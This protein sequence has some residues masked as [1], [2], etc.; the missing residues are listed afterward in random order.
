M[1]IYM[2]KRGNGERKKIL[3]SHGL[4]IWV[5]TGKGG[6]NGDDIL[7]MLLTDS[8][9]TPKTHG[10]MKGF[11]HMGET[12]PKSTGKVGSHGLSSCCF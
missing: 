4:I 2:N 3:P 9:W 7:A 1:N 8:L 6:I 5:L 11:K 12:T 10:K